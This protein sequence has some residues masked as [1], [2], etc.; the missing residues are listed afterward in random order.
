MKNR[1]VIF[2]L[3]GVICFLAQGTQ[4]AEK[5]FPNRPIQVIIPFQ[6]GETDSLL[7]PFIEKLPEYLGQP[8]TFVYKPGAA[9][10]VG[11]GFVAGSKPDGYTLLGSSQSSVSL[12]P[13]S[14]KDLA[15]TTESFVPVT[16]LAEG[17]LLLAVQSNA[18]WKNI[19][20]F[21]TEAKNHPEKLSYASTGTFGISHI[22]GEAF[23]NAA[24][25]KLTH[26]PAQ[27]S[28]PAVTAVLGGHVDAAVTGSGPSVPHIKAGA[29]R[30]LGVFN[31]KR[32]RA[33]P[34]VPSCHEAGF[35]V[36]LPLKYGL[37]APKGTPKNIVDTLYEAA[38]K[39]V[40]KNQQVLEDRLLTSGAQVGFMGPK[41]YSDILKAQHQYF[42]TILKRSKLT[43][44]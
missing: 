33:L 31:E 21:V 10:G 18:R 24:G 6:P 41:E 5:S 26:I 20:E 25:I 38:K 34:D 15:Y 14:N 29:L 11:A 16:C 4:A 3:L 23:C 8:V 13:L 35:S 39:M 37:L 19:Q 9:G 17:Y 32:V 43:P 22:A 7:R 40:E 36:I 28:G 44:N 2:F 27:G 1:Q 12:L 30:A 42:E